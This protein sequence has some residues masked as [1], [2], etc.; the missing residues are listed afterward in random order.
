VPTFPSVRNVVLVGH[1][2]AGKT[3]LAEALLTRTGAVTRAGRVEDGTTVTDHDDIEH[4]L[5]RSVS[6]SVA[7][8]VVADDDLVAGTAAAPVRVTV[9][10]TPGHPD[11]VGELRAGLR[12]ADAAL[13]VVSAVDGISAATR[14]V[15]QE[16]ASVGMPRAVVVTHVDQPRGDFEAVVEVC[17]RLFGAGLQ[18]L[19]LPLLADDDSP[20]GLIGLL[21]GTLYDSSGGTRTTRP[22]EP[23]HLE[24]V[25]ARRSALVEGIIAE[26]EDE[27][28]LD[29]YLAGDDIDEA[30]LVDDLE[31]AVARGSFHPV[32][33]V[34]PTSGLG[35]DE[36]LELVVRGF[37][38]P[39][40]HPL[41]PVTTPDGEPREALVCD[42]EGPLVAEVVRTTT[43]PYV[44]RV[45]LVRVFSGTL[46]PDSPVHVSGHLGDRTA[47]H[48]D[49]HPDHDVDERVGA[50][51]RLQGA[52]GT[53][54][55]RAV[56]GD[57]VAVARL[58][59]AETGD[60]LS[61]PAGP[62]LLEPWVL[63][64]P[65]LPVAVSPPSASQEPRL[66][67]G[68]ARLRAEDPTV[69]LEVDPA[70]HQ[71]VLWT[72]GEAHRDVLL[73]RLRTRW[74][75]EVVTSPVRV[76]V[77]ETF[78]G[79][80]SGHGRH[81]K[82]S[83]G[84]GQYAVVDLEVEPLGEGAGVEF[85]DAVTGGAV[86]RRYVPAV[87]KGVRVRLARGLAA[88]YP[89][90]DVLVRLVGGK[91][92]A[93]DSS[94]AAFATA[95]GLALEAAAR[96]GGIALLEPV[97]AVTTVVDDEFLG[98]VLADLSG[99]RARVRSTGPVG[100]G[101]TSVDAEVPAFEL[102][103]YAADLRGLGHGTASFVRTYAHH[104]PAPPQVAARLA[105]AGE[106]PSA[107]PGV[108]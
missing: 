65:L 55:P 26:S 19:Y 40:E 44:G 2:G 54:V 36:L 73:E 24:A 16:C 80:A 47:G 17:Q 107:G 22:A 101:R 53:S 35:V 59:R 108:S 96:A 57:I 58:A 48:E 90:V 34:V 77:R 46:L 31:T 74:G 72:L 66:A 28:L 86:P 50:L 43:D 83:G 3:T 105:D 49:W 70:T 92:H 63:P 8:A 37:P 25:Q 94:E 87:E 99:R 52:T 33:P 69:R 93:V 89:V 68:L 10:D 29:R 81:V 71:V 7:D 27:T 9:V 4:R 98:S 79:P 97:D 56:A 15:W 103:R 12:A 14:L 76:A 6:L 51:S 45:C 41:P 23:Q 102:T 11:F 67:E 38:S 32:L 30:T 64:E 42:P 85:V 13:F 88:G 78:R 95:A 106:A 62:A 1:P 82:Q 20:V 75:V 100:P 39:P 104:A 21:T 61:D 5:G 84:H 18:A 91:A 60:T